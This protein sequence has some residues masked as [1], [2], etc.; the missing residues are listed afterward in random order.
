MIYQEEKYK[1]ILPELEPLM[2]ELASEV[3]LYPEEPKVNVDHETLGSMDTLQL[4]TA[5][6]DNRLVGFHIA[7]VQPD[8]FYK[9]ILTGFVLLYY[10]LP[11]Y[12]GRGK[13]TGLFEY[14]EM[15]YKKKKVQRVFMS[16]KI[17]IPN[18]KVFTSLGY[19]QIEANYT[20]A[21]K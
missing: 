12:R 17:Y 9:H 11:E 8:L 7:T 13:G 15:L 6:Q 18:E 21:I 16:R 1:D 5:R 2:L 4:I 3:D 14:A 10:M 20:K 19:T